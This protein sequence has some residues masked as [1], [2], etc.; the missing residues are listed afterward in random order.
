[1]G[2]AQYSFERY[3][4]VRAAYGASFSPDGQILSFLT[5]ITGVAEVWSVPVISQETAQAARPSWPSQLTFRGERIAGATFSPKEQTLLA[6]G[7]VGGNELTQLYTLSAD[8]SAF[9]ALTS[10]PE[11]M[12]LFGDWSPDGKRIT[13]SSN[14]RDSR[15]FDVYERDMESG[16]VKLLLQQDG[17]NY[18]RSYSPDG[19]QVLVAHQVSNICNQLILVDRVT[20]EQRNLT[21][22]AG[23]GPAL[24]QMAAWSADQRGL[25]LVSNR[26][27]QFLSLAYLNLATTELT[28]LSDTPWDVE[29]LAVTQDGRFLATAVNE[30]GYSRLELFDVSNGW[31]AR[32]ELMGPTLPG[33]VVYEITWSLDGTKLAVVFASAIDTRDIWVWDM[34]AANVQ[35]ATQSSLG[36]IRRETLA[37]PSLVHYPTFDGREIPG[38]LYLPAGQPPA[39]PVVIIVHGGPES[40]A[41]PVFDPVSQYLVASGYGVFIPNVRGST[42]YGYEYQSLDDVRKRMD[43]VAD[44]QYAAFWLGK[45]GIADPRRIAVMGGSYG[46]FMVLSA[47]TTYPDLWAA[48]VDIVGIANFVTFLENTGPWRRKL[49]EAEYGSLENDREFLERISPIRSVDRITAPLFVIHGANDPRVPVGEA[50]Q[51]VSA[52]RSRNVPVEYLRFEDEGH[53]LV[54]RNNRLVAYPAIADFLEQYLG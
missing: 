43:S 48:A 8:G 20:G 39:L 37:T 1:M 25:Y 27:R 6:T 19:Q 17:T 3:L 47:I 35:R 29:L 33:G 5:D 45:S 36:G 15:Y 53:G 21:P 13:Y 31:E 34:H 52:L 14:E 10:R 11:V 51:I 18:A 49:R 2:K 28:F 16:A 22:E 30:D 46:G 4:N 23:E 7:D 12:Y 9:E 41:R 26:G 50:E 44:L 38:F 24:H 42:G 32:Q 40:Q 54:K